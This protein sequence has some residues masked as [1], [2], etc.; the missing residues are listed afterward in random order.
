M[1]VS[2]VDRVANDPFFDFNGSVIINVR[3]GP[4]TLVRVFS[5]FRFSLIFLKY[6]IFWFVYVSYAFFVFAYIVFTR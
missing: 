3:N 5:V 4:W 2:Y 1:Y 6:Q